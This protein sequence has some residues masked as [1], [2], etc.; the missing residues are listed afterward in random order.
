MAF[1]FK[2]LGRRKWYARFT[3]PVTK[4]IVTRAG[5]TD[6]VATEALARRLEREAAR[7]F[8]GI[9]VRSGV[10][11]QPIGEHV[12]AFESHLLA[13]GDTEKHAGM[14]VAHVRRI[15]AGCRWTVLADLSASGAEKWLADQRKADGAEVKREGKTPSGV[16]KRRRFGMQTSNHYLR[17][18]KHFVRW[19][20]LDRRLSVDP[21][22]HLAMQN[23][24]TDVRHRRRALESSELSRLLE[25]T[26]SAKTRYGLTGPA[27]AVLYLAAARTG[28]RAEELASLV[29]ESFDLR[30]NPPEWTLGAGADKAGRGDKLP[31]AAELAEALRSLLP[32]ITPGSRVWPGRWAVDHAAAKML[33]GDLKVAKIPYRTPGGVFDF[34]ALRV[35]FITDLARSGVSLQ[36]AQRLAR[37]SDPRLTSTIYTRL[38]QADLAGELE[39]LPP[40]G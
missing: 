20:I 34:H 4:K 22:V 11:R 9:G 14:R 10:A 21:F 12:D 35:Q 7:E 18:L 1:V 6:K 37:H 8:E 29:P 5:Y 25:S 40:A 23:V 15:I 32:T 16:H 28:L 26:R 13:K 19:L 27:R 3:H 2:P 38:G 31:V 39:K 33:R 17:S 36:A 24:K 30:T